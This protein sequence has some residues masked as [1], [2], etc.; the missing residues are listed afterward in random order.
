MELA[1]NKNIKIKFCTTEKM[2]K[3]TGTKQHEGVSI[4]AQK[5][6]YKDLKKFNELSKILRKK[7]QN[8]VVFTHRVTGY[9]HFASIVQ[10][11]LFLGAD[12]IIS[13]K[14]ERHVLDSSLAKASFGATEAIELY[15]VKFVNQF[16]HGI[17]IV[18]V[19]AQRNGW[20]IIYVE[21]GQAPELKS[22]KEESI[23]LSD[24]QVESSGNYIVVLSASYKSDE[25]R[26]LA[27][28]SDYTVFIPPHL[29]KNKINKYPFNFIS[30]LNIGVSAGI[31]L[32]HLRN[33]FKISK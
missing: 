6:D 15:C 7:E 33:S 22:E 16:L 30:S 14:E 4:N 19:D 12:F 1:K 13:G 17:I 21:E 29:D 25:N 27:K 3:L 2:D 9:I 11:A 28:Q 24:L 31:V 8:I 18:Y 26:T 10:T 20:K 32:S 5:R 23:A